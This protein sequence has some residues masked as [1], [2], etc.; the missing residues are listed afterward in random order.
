MTRKLMMA[1]LL[2]CS[3]SG[4]TVV[5]AA[6]KQPLIQVNLAG[7]E[8]GTVPG[9]N[10]FDYMFP[11]IESLDKWKANGI[12]VIR[13]PILWERLQPALNGKLDAIYAPAIDET[14]ARAQARGMSVIID[15]HNYGQY[16]KQTIGSAA[17]PLASYKN[18]LERMAERWHSSPGLHGYD[19]MNEPHDGADAAWPAI[20]QAGI[21]GV[22]K[23]DKVRPIYVEGR[24]WSNAL[25]WPAFNGPLLLLRDPSNNIIFSAHLYLDP[26]T[27]GFYKN[28]PAK[29]F[30]LNIG[31]NRAKP[32]V[33]WLVRNKRNGHI[34]EFGV[35]NSDP[36]WSQAMDRL[37]AYLKLHCVP[38]AYWAAGP[39]W[40]D[41]PLS[42][43]P[44]TGVKVP[45]WTVLDRYV[46]DGNNCSNPF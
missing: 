33:E 22:R 20:A 26:D 4:V 31:V 34:G 45:Q 16:K 30:D 8:F 18:L 3:A 27:S 17:V 43:E 19:L 25:N 6:D 15:I 37:L 23:Y 44:R 42:I 24:A 13:V 38:L 11:T 2:A 32:F 7:A 14:L 1:L 9:R 39:L 40:G 5:N 28:P 10:G 41:Y 46:R 21:D 35:P 29:D 12:K 36:R